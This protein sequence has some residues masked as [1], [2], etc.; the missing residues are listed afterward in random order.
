[1][2]GSIILLFLT[3]AGSLYLEAQLVNWIAYEIVVLFLGVIF[4][5]VLVA[6]EAMR[7]R[8]VWNLST[9]YYSVALANLAGLYM[10]TGQLMVFLGTLVVVTVAFIRSISNLNLDWEDVEA[11][12]LET[13]EEEV[14]T[15][16]T[17]DPIIVQTTERARKTR[18]KSKRTR[19]KTR[20]A[21][22]KTRRR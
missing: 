2:I 19:K 18:K 9:V 4:A 20:K 10:A 16:D 13:Y 12:P 11:E 17:V 22:R 1:M 15:P 14:Y 8:W 6:G 7:S 21:R 5:F 3:F